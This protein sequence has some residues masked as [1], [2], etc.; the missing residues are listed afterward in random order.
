MK[1]DLHVHT[2]VSDSSCSIEETIKMA[3][4]RRVTHLGIVDHDTTDGLIEAIEFGKKYGV[5]V[6]PGIEISAYDFEKKKKVHILG[7]QFDL[8]APNIKKICDKIIK[9][10]HNNSL[11]Q[12]ERLYENGYDIRL[13]DIEEKAERS[14]CIYKQH[15]MEVLVEKGY[16]TEMYSSLYQEIFKGNGICARDIEYASAFDAVKAVKDDGGIAILAHPGQFNSYYLI[17]DLVKAGLDGIEMYHQYHT[18]EDHKII[19][20]YREKHD[21]I[22][23]GGSDY[24]GKYGAK[25]IQIGEIT[26]PEEYIKYFNKVF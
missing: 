2:N 6:I 24:H 20:Q 17:D 13:K 14:R 9:R 23:T 15:I 25:E 1:V 7:F 11:W 12:I 18:D 26:T 3:K 16:T 22:L 4:E 8:A 21:L 5:K 10:R 19:A